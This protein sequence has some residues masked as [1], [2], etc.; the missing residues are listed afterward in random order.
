MYFSDFVF[1]FVFDDNALIM[2]ERLS[3]VGEE[4]PAAVFVA[5]CHILLHFIITLLPT[6]YMSC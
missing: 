3:G 2:F 1:V 5:L 6:H 4:D